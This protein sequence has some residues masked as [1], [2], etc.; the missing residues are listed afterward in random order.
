M[1]EFQIESDEGLPI[2]GVLESAARPKALV[3]IVHGFK[4]FAEWGF[5]P[6]LTGQFVAHGLAACRFD[7]S[8]NGIGDVRDSFDRLDLFERDTYSIQLADLR[9]VVRHLQSRTPFGQLPI[10]LVGHSRGGAIALLAAESV[11]NLHGVVTWSSIARTGRWDEL[12]K[13]RWRA[14]GWL[15]MENARTRQTMKIGTD[16]LDDLDQHQRELDV[17]AAVARLKVPLLAIHGGRDETVPL[18]EG[19]QIARAGANASLLVLHRASHTL[20][21]IHPLIHVPK[22]LTMAAIVSAHFATA[23]L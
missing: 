6:W 17:L 18:E 14:D 8:R 19:R 12:L 11:P 13:R 3:V 9:A 23:W 5:F 16:I 7:M 2:R 15:A 22:E 20:N 4:G 10:F 1:P 21:A